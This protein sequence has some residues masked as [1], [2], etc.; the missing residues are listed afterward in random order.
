LSNRFLEDSVRWLLLLAL[1]SCAKAPEPAPAPLP[2]AVAPAGLR[3]YAEQRLFDK[4]VV[5]GQVVARDENGDPDMRGDSPLY[6]GIAI[7]SLD[8]DRG[9][10]LMNRLQERIAENNGARERFYPWD[11]NVA[12]NR[13]SWDQEVG[14]TYAFARRAARCPDPALGLHWT[15][16]RDAADKSVTPPGFDYVN[17]A[18]GAKLGVNGAPHKDRQQIFEFEAQAW[19]ALVVA[20][21]SECYRLHL[22][23]RSLLSAEAVGRPIGGYGRSRF[24]HHTRN[25]QIPIIDRWCGRPDTYLATFQFNE[26]RFRHGKCLWQGGPDGSADRESPAVDLLDYIATS[27]PAL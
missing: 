13:W 11:D 23:F 14:D 9:A 24:C 25:A 2:A 4:F 19:A 5:D 8:C 12:Q 16:L 1:I 15:I 6:T 20:A 27:E 18:V 21:R 26:Y 10:P 17:D 3:E 22:A 7:G